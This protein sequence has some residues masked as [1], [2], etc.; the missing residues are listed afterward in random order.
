MQRFLFSKI[1]H[2][3]LFCL[4]L[5]PSS[6]LGNQLQPSATSSNR[7]FIAVLKQEQVVGCVGVLLFFDG[8]LGDGH[9]S[10]ALLPFKHILL[11]QTTVLSCRFDMVHALCHLTS[12]FPLLVLFVYHTPTSGRLQSGSSFAIRLCVHEIGAVVLM[13]WGCL[14][15]FFGFS[16]CF[17]ASTSFEGVTLCP[18]V[19]NLK[20][21]V[22]TLFVILPCLAL[23][24]SMMGPTQ[25]L[26]EIFRSP[27]IRLTNSNTGSR[28]L[29]LMSR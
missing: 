8:P 19:A 22:I 13:L 26:K 10:K 3:S 18:L 1:L 21:E 23:K 28:E 24:E 9:G 2:N 11:P 6:R 27:S 12:L 16:W 20:V 5:Y 7:C 17:L 29:P 4:Y 14:N 25:E 15:H